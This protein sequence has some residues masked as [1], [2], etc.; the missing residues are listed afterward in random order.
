[1]PHETVL[2]HGHAL[3]PGLTEWLVAELAVRK[4]TFRARGVRKMAFR[5]QPDTRRRAGG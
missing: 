4:A 1:V 2:T 5:T 3:V